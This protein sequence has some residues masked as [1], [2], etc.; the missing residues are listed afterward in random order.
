MTLLI[1]MQYE[2]AAVTVA[3]VQHVHTLLFNYTFY[4]NNYYKLKLM[5]NNYPFELQA[6]TTAE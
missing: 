6:R 3:F 2:Q 5:Q 4:Y 1:V